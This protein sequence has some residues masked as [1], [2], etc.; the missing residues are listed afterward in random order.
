MS[1][2]EATAEDSFDSLTAAEKVDVVRRVDSAL[3]GLREDDVAI[4]KA[5]LCMIQMDDETLKSTRERLLGNKQLAGVTR[6]I[7]ISTVFEAQ[8][9]HHSITGPSETTAPAESTSNLLPY[10][11]EAAISSDTAPNNPSR[12]RPRAEHI[13]TLGSRMNLGDQ[14]APSNLN[15]RKAAEVPEIERQPKQRRKNK[16][17]RISKKADGSQVAARP[18]VYEWVKPLKEPKV[19]SW[20]CRVCYNWNSKFHQRCKGYDNSDPDDH[21]RCRGRKYSHTLCLQEADGKAAREKEP[22]AGEWLC[23]FCG[24]WNLRSAQDCENKGEGLDFGMCAIDVEEA[25]EYRQEEDATHQR[26]P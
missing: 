19:G 21:T 4:R 5:M 1:D 14:P 16:Q 7:Q 3:W 9:H 26:R 13:N 12:S 25:C 17:H 11:D 6:S 8:P 23:R 2:R 10:S 24:Y 18:K 15:K 20:K 22:Y